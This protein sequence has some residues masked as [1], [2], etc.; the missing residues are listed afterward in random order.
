ME[1][2]ETYIRIIGPESGAMTAYG[3]HLT[4]KVAEQS[5]LAEFSQL[6]EVSVERGFYMK[7]E[8]RSINLDLVLA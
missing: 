1:R 3:V 2:A 5:R 8:T 4:L 6:G 7:M